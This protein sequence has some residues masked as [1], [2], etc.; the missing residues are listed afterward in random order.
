MG[1][2]TRGEYT[3]GECTRGEYTRGECTRGE[4]TRSECTRGPAAR[5]GVGEEATSREWI[6]CYRPNTSRKACNI[7]E[8]TK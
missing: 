4:Y 1:E 5:R 2:C 6:S 7:K 3:R 8:I